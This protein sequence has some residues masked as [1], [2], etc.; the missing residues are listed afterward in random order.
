VHRTDVYNEQ[1]GLEQLLHD[2]YQPPL[3]RVRPI[4]PTNPN[5]PLY[6]DAANTFLGP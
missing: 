4:S 5:L 6:Q 1:R 3:K 2:T